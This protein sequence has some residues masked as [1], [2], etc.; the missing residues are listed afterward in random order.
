MASGKTAMARK[1]A[2]IIEYQFVDTDF[3]FADKMKINVADFINIYG[4]EEFRKHESLVLQEIVKANN[5]VVATGGGTPCFFNNMQLIN[6]NGVSIYLKIPTNI[7]TKRII[8]SKTQRPLVQG[9]SP[10][11][12][13]SFIDN[14]ISQREKFYSQSHH[15][16]EAKTLIP[17][18][19]LKM[20]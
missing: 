17:E 10:E 6:E 20:F 1:L 7:L 4:E 8:N 9:I 19:I 3:A 11:D 15:F 5:Q 13:P 12:L 14:M 16:I 18:D 2:K